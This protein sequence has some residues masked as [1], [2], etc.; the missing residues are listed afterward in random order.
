MTDTEL[1]SIG[2]FAKLVGLTASALRFYDDAG[3]LRPDEVIPLTGYRM[4]SPSQLTRAFQLRQLREIGMP[5]PIVEK[6]FTADAEE[7]AL[8]ID[9]Q[10]AKAAKGA[11][12]VQEAAAGLKASLG[13]QPQLMICSLPGPVLA[14]AVDDVLATTIHD[15]D[16]PI[17]NGV[18]LAADSESVTLTATDR[19]R[20]ATR[21]LV[22][23]HSSGESW[24]G[25]LSGD[26]LRALTPRLRRSVTVKLA[27]GKRALSILLGDGTV[28]Y[29]RLLTGAFPDHRL[30]LDSLAPSSC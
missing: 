24:A 14:G 4:Y 8:L 12:A 6:F 15:P 29:C 11:S 28:L 30:L 5:L 13:H 2:A 22:P 7:A 17:L 16:M 9:E 19:Y 23:A 25:T 1:M 3:V 26:D 20:L 27:A 18:R 10:A 21:T